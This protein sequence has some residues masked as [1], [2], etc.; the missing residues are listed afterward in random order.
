MNPN[1]L[2]FEQP[3]AELESKIEEL[4]KVSSEANLNVNDEIDRLRKKSL[5]WITL[6]GCLP[7]SMTSMATGVLPMML[8]SSLA[9]PASRASLWL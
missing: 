1:Y 2:D 7:T 8:P 3:I 4:R 9:L 6:R 5:S